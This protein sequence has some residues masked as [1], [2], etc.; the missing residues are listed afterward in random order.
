MNFETDKTLNLSRLG[1]FSKLY[2]AFGLFSHIQIVWI[3][4]YFVLFLVVMHNYQNLSARKNVERLLNDDA[5]IID[6]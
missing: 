3:C 5:Y 1:K 6:M 4:K 2:Q